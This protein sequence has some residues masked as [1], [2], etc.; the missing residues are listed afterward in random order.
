MDK[1][2]TLHTCYDI[3]LFLSCVLCF[4]RIITLF[5]IEK[6]CFHSSLVGKGEIDNFSVSMRI[7]GFVF[8]KMFLEQS[9][10]LRINFV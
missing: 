4:A 10:V 8:T 9:S 6:L 7:F 3:S 2:D 1:A 5:A